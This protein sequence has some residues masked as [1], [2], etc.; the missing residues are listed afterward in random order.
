MIFYSQMC[1]YNVIYHI[2]TCNSCVGRRRG[3]GGNQVTAFICMYVCA[4]TYN[5]CAFEL[6]VEKLIVIKYV[7]QCIHTP[8]HMQAYVYICNL[9]TF[10]KIYIT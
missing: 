8:K 2:N 5:V 9:F 10:H 4:Y 1:V 7:T 6:A 3:R